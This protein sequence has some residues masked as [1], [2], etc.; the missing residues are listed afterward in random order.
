GN[1]G[2]GR[3]VHAP[4]LNAETAENAENAEQKAS[5][6]SAISARSALLEVQFESDL[7]LALRKLRLRLTELR[8]LQAALITGEI[9]CIQDVE[10]F[11]EAGRRPAAA[12]AETLAHPQV[13]AAIV[14]R[15]SR[16]ARL[17][18]GKDDRRARHAVRQ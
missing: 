18:P 6:I 9:V 10:R 8:R 1:R 17:R 16:S 2:T 13:H 11:P 3:A 4:L 7:L 15:A 5:A 12:K 14:I